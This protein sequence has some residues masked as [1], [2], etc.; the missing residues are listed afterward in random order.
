MSSQAL[1]LVDVP[2]HERLRGSSLDKHAKDARG[3][4]FVI[5]SAK[6]GKED[7]FKAAQFLFD[8]LSMRALKDAKFLLFFNKQV[9]V[10]RGLQYRVPGARGGLVALDAHSPAHT[11]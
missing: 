5:D 8:L 9:R 4:A 10:K 7:I 2:G 3:V 6:I 11:N 1:G